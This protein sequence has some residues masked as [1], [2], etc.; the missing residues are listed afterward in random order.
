MS[1]CPDSAHGHEL[2]YHEMFAIPDDPLRLKQRADCVHCGTRMWVVYER[3]H[4]EACPIEDRGYPL[5][6]EIRDDGTLV[7]P[8]E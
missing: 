5:A 4:V 1:D 2:D 7:A 8:F 6:T 3:S